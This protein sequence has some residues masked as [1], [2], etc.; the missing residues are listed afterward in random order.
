MDRHPAK[1]KPVLD[2]HDGLAQFGSLHRRPA[3]GRAAAD[4]QEI[5]M[6]QAASSR[7]DVKD[8]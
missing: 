5:E 1:A 2:D 4:N 8:A 7:Y 6:F 3:P